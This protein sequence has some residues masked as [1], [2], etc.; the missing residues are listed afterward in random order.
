MNLGEQEKDNEKRGRE[1]E[2]KRKAEGEASAEKWSGPCLPTDGQWE[3]KEQRHEH[4]PR[5]PALFPAASPS[6]GIAA[7]YPGLGRERPLRLGKPAPRVPLQLPGS[8]ERVG[9]V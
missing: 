2:A 1:M 9:I 4:L 6:P 3:E 5:V 8:D 7:E